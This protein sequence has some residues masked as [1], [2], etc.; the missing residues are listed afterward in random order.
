MAETLN[1]QMT[2]ND[3]RKIKGVRTMNF[4]DSRILCVDDDTRTCD[5]IRIIL[6]GS[7]VDAL[8]RVAKTG[9]EA[10]TLLNQEDFDLCIL[11]YALPDMTGVQLCA[12]LRQTGCDVPMMFLTAMGRPIDRERA[13]A[14][15]A[16]AYLCKP[17]D[18]DIVVSAVTHLLTIR[19]PI[20]AQNTRLSS[21]L[22]A[23]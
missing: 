6:R 9:R 12:L 13:N 10:F 11:E 8:V 4:S 15:G 21:V 1:D 23:A 2:E 5:W 18:L 19:R 3:D 17:D 14:A 7:K 20:Y 22:K 16:N